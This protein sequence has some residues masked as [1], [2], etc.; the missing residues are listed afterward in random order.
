M[1]NSIAFGNQSD[2]VKE[3]NK[4]IDGSLRLF[5]GQVGD[6]EFLSIFLD[7]ERGTGLG[8]G[9]KDN[10][11]EGKDLSLSLLNCTGAEGEVLT[12]R[13]DFSKEH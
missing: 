10:V 7:P 6:E 8:C 1:E 13:Q 11:S 9:S 4:Q 5:L 12:L 3:R 2:I